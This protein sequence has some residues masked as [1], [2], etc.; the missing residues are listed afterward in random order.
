MFRMGY[1][2]TVRIRNLT[3]QNGNGA[4]GAAIYFAGELLDI[5]NCIFKNNKAKSGGVIASRGKNVVIRNSN[6]INQ[7]TE[8]S[9]Y[10]GVI[11][12][13]GKSSVGGGSLIIDGCTFANNALSGTSFSGSVICTREETNNVHT[14]LD[15]IRIANSTFYQNGSSS[16]NAVTG[17]VIC[18][19]TPRN[20]PNN[21][22]TS[23]ALINNTF[24]KNQTG[25][26]YMK[27]DNYDLTLVNNVIAGNLGYTDCAIGTEKTTD[28]GRTSI[29]AKNNV[30][31]AKAALN[32]NVSLSEFDDSN[33]L[34]S[35]TATA[36]VDALFL[37]S[38]LVTPVKGIPYL[39][40]KKGN[41]PLVDA[42]TTS[43]PGQI[44]P[45]RDA[46][47]TIRG[48]KNQT[49]NGYDIGA[50][51]YSNRSVVWKGDNSSVWQDNRNWEGNAVPSYTRDILIPAGA[52]TFPTIPDKTTVNTI[53]FERG[54]KANLSGSLTATEAVKVDYTVE[55]EKW[56]SIGFP[57]DVAAVY[58][59][60]FESQ[61]WPPY[62]LT[63]YSEES[64]TGDFWLKAY[65]PSGEENLFYYV[66]E[67]EA[68]KGYIIQFPSWF[69]GTKI[70]F[71][72]ESNPTL[73]NAGVLPVENNY[74]LVANPT[75]NDLTLTAPN[76]NT[77][78]YTFKAN[79]GTNGEYVRLTDGSETLSPFES[80][81]TISASDAS[82]LAYSIGASGELTG[83][84]P[85]PFIADDPVIA[86][87]YYTFSGL[88]IRK[89]LE[90]GIYLVKKVHR[91]G[92][93]EIIKTVYNKK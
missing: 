40:I 58:S 25:V 64:H 60:Y 2:R 23:V 71:I 18:L 67:I 91:S 32:A 89:P 72:S 16:N 51:E 59:H 5:E 90:P 19:E 78:Y 22:K 45:S 29:V 14:Y 21:Q 39:P 79:S 73:D 85:V 61:A 47:G 75:L 36:P 44:I 7:S 70:T 35:T 49:G 56:Y 65:N 11:T 81:I 88:E 80:A 62:D 69:D 12:H 28:S 1:D 4:P 83:L 38:E 76:G 54:A 13:G 15:E 31:I 43:V 77:Y 82:S 87:H 46:F 86:T 74:Q 10:G 84:N 66:S 20:L 3:M 53:T 55:R 52:A 41:S 6:F 26:I 8:S 93:N 50:F 33:S 30:I 68:G 57:F 17:A 48:N 37:A 34:T 24:Y 9:G 42:A 92:K 27:S 63:A